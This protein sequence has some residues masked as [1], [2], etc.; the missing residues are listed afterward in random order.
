MG[1]QSKAKIGS[2]KSRIALAQDPLS[3]YLTPSSLKALPSLSRAGGPA[4]SST[5]LFCPPPPS[6]AT[7]SQQPPSQPVYSCAHSIARV[8]LSVSKLVRLTL[9]RRDSSLAFASQTLGFVAIPSG[10]LKFVSQ[11][12]HQHRPPSSPGKVRQQP[13]QPPAKSFACLAQCVTF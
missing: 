8:T 9:L 7:G 3:H 2:S 6:P 5:P 13:L 11:P 1:E 12:A 10:T 4:F